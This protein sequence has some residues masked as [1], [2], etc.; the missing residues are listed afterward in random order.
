MALPRTARIDILA[1]W[2]DKIAVLVSEPDAGIYD[3]MNKGIRKSTGDLIYFLNS[4]DYFYS[5]KAVELM[6][7]FMRSHPRRGR[8]IWRDRSPHEGEVAACLHAPCGG[9]RS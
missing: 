4:D 9:E 8:C 7:D 6:V 3:A 1:K 2:R 5:P